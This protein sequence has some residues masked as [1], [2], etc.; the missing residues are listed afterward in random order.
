MSATAKEDAV[1]QQR[2]SQRRRRRTVKP[3]RNISDD[4][5][6]NDGVAAITCTVDVALSRVFIC[7]CVCR[8]CRIFKR[9]SPS[10]KDNVDDI[11]EEQIDDD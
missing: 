2:R 9:I 4:G 6:D 8:Y 7:L 5:D 11:I 1:V 3:F 10:A